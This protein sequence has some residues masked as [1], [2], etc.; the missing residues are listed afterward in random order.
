MEKKSEI[1]NK[2]VQTYAEDMV[3]VLEDDK[4]GLIKKIIHG[5]E[6]N[7]IEKR[8]LSPESVKNR[9]FMLIGLLF[10]LFGFTTLFYFILMRDVPTVPVEKQFMSLIFHD[11]S[12]FI[13]VKDFKKEEIAR[14]V[15]N[16]VNTTKVKNGEVEGIYLTYDK[17][18]IGLRKF[19]ELIKGNFILSNSNFV[20]DNFLL[21]VV[22]SETKDFFMLLKMRSVTD[23]FGSLRIWESKMFFDLH[24][25]HF[26]I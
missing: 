22:N 11:T 17:K 1:K 18:V 26:H 15:F 9:F 16:E 3:K 10:I 4:S 21:G 12:T 20:D 13:E 24:P 2:I 25:F 5:E 8:N 6:E 14:T 23:I 19:L 7:E